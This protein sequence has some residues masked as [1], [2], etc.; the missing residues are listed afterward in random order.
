LSEREDDR[1]LFAWIHLADA[2][3]EHA[4]HDHF[5]VESTLDAYDNELRW[6][7]FNLAT[8]FAAIHRR[9][10]DDVVVAL[11]SDHGEEFGERG[12]Y[13][14]GFSLREPMVHVPLLVR[15]PGLEPGV[16]T[17]PV[18]VAGVPA[19][20][21]SLIGEKSGLMTVP[22]VLAPEHDTVVLGNPFFWV[23]NRMEVAL[24]ES[25]WKLI[26]NRS[27]DTAVL[28]DLE[29]DPDEHHNLAGEQPDE[30]SRMQQRLFDALEQL[31]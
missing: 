12:A 13:G 28:F 26:V 10:G 11:T 27:Q 14:H 2:H 21:L 20:L 6:L 9:Y 18:N 3:A 15:A 17:R 29:A 22:S 30:L 25:R 1:P 8:I 5:P 16:E 4:S 31:R 23:E 7:D 24:V 19:T